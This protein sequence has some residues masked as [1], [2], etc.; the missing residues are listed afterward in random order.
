MLTA[1]PSTSDVI[2]LPHSDLLQHF[3]CCTP[4]EDVPNEYTFFRNQLF[5]CHISSPYSGFSCTL[6]THHVGVGNIATIE[7]QLLREGVVKV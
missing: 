1:V 2:F 5:F 3:I 6:C 4:D 7:V